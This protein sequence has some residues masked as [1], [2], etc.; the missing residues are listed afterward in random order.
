[1]V[2]DG[3]VRGVQLEQACSDRGGSIAAYGFDV[4]CGCVYDVALV[5]WREDGGLLW[6]S[7]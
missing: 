6:F 2:S 3:E 5:G 1:M 7:W 4:Y